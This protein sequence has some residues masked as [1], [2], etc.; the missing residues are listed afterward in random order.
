MS[1]VFL[2]CRLLFG[3]R[4]DAE[5][6]LLDD[7]LVQISRTVLTKR[8]KN[9]LSPGRELFSASED[10]LLSN[11]GH[12]FLK[13]HDSLEANLTIVQLRGVQRKSLR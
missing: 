2:T 8:P 12:F 6:Y 10:A 13:V 11:P 7:P 3:H 5:K 1:D 9:F 4:T